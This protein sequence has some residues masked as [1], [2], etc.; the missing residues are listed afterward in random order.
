MSIYHLYLTFSII[1]CQ[2]I[3]VDNNGK[4][5][6]SITPTYGGLVQL[7]CG[8]SKHRGKAWYTTNSATIKNT[9]GVIFTDS[10]Q[11]RTLAFLN[12]NASYAGTYSCVLSAMAHPYEEPVT[13]M[14]TLG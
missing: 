14:V 12:F 3:T 8:W 11:T 13:Y 5:D 9:P 7:F 2:N 1:V 6:V 4:T 10:G